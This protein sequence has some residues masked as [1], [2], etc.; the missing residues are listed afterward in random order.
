MDGGWMITFAAG[1]A[2]T[3]GPQ[4]QQ[5]QKASVKQSVVSSFV[6][7]TQTCIM[8]LVNK[9]GWGELE[10]IGIRL[11]SA[12][13]TNWREEKRY[14][15]QRRLQIGDTKT[16]DDLEADNNHP[17]PLPPSPLQ[18]PTKTTAVRA[19]PAEEERLLG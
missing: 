15:D 6:L 2:A 10:Q 19:L 3:D 5:Q 8:Y 7:C 12:A 13:G 11:L 17:P 4:Q 16:N 14:K 9:E 1:L 18:Q